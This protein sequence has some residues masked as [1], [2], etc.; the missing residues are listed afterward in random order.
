[1]NERQPSSIFESRLTPGLQGAFLAIS[2]WSKLLA[3]IGFALGAFIV[4][5]ILLSGSG[6]ITKIE[7]LIS[8]K[9]PGLYSA[10]IIAFFILFF[11]AAAVLYFLYKGATLLR[12][13]VQQN[14]TTLIAEGFTFLKRFF[15]ISAI[16]SAIS[17]TVNLFSL[18]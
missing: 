17:L 11:I 2:K 14:D 8:I 4:V 15:I 18:F 3:V 5:T 13:G 1:M 7:S 16:V 12:Q 9:I 10:L 6:M